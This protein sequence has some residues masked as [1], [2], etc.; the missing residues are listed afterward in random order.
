[1]TLVVATGDGTNRESEPRDILGQ[2]LGSTSVKSGSSGGDA[3]P[4][5]HLVDGEIPREFADH[6]EE[7][8]KIEEEEDENQD[9]VEPQGRQ[10]ERGNR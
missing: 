8:G 3:D 4:P 9:E 2:E 7:E 5:T 6:E 10:T 1:M